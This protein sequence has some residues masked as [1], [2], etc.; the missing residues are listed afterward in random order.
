MPIRKDDEVLV[1][2]GTHKGREGKVTSV[3]RLKC[4]APLCTAKC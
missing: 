3:Y 4:T 2:R 1:V